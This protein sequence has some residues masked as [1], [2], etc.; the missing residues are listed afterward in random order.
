MKSIEEMIREPK[1]LPLFMNMNCIQKQVWK[2][3]IWVNPFEKKD[4]LQED[5]RKWNDQSS[6]NKKRQFRNH[7]VQIEPRMLENY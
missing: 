1:R 5:S 2:S 6:D 7:G 4:K 3:M